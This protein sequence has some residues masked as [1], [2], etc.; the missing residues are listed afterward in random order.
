MNSLWNVAFADTF[1]RLALL[2]VPQAGLVDCTSALPP[3]RDS[4]PGANP[5]TP[6]YTSGYSSGVGGSAPTGHPGG[7]HVGGRGD[8]GRYH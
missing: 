1:S 8:P 3:P 2:G 5:S 6:S 7:S 4:F